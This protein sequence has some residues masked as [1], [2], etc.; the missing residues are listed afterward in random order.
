MNGLNIVVIVLL[1]GISYG[2]YQVINA[3]SP[4]STYADNDLVE[5][6]IEIHAP[7][8]GG[9][10]WPT[11]PPPPDGTL[12]SPR[13][14]ELVQPAPTAPPSTS[15]SALPNPP[16]LASSPAPS[17]S[18]LD[19]VQS[20]ALGL[21]KDRTRGTTTRDRMILVEVMTA[22]LD[23]GWWRRYRLQLQARFRQDAIVARAVRISAL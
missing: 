20:P 13:S 8:T 17:P 23:R 14:T 11:L 22:R 18:G 1:L 4:T 16:S 19:V 21:W 6:Q 7:T 10:E 3:P 12:S 5:P 2:A 9:P 15:P